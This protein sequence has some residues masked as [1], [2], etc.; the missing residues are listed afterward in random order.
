MPGYD[1]AKDETLWTKDVYDD[2]KKIGLEL[3][4][5]RYDGGPAKVAIKRFGKKKDGSR[6]YPKGER[7]TRSEAIWLSGALTEAV[8]QIQSLTAGPK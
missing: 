7:F 2:A 8:V 1:P 6:Y 3:K 4:V 5:C